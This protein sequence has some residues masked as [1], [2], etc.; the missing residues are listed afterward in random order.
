ME[1]IKMFYNINIVTI[2]KHNF[3]CSRDKSF[4][5]NTRFMY[6]YISNDIHEQLILYLTC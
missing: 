4:K 1:N 5:T 6:G 2:G 3:Q